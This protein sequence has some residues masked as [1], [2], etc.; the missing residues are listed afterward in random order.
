[1]RPSPEMIPVL[2][3]AARALNG[4]QKRAFMARTV[5]AVGR[6]GQRWAQEHLG[7]SWC[8]TSSM[9]DAVL[10]HLASRVRPG[11]L[12]RSPHG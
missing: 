11:R 10:P 9:A 7:D 2:I 8:V 5:A 3:D 6:G 4:S 12:E 1:M